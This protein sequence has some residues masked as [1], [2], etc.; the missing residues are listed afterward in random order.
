MGQVPPQVGHAR[1]GHEGSH[2]LQLLQALQTMQVSQPCVGDA[3]FVQP[4]RFQL[5]E[6]FETGEAGIGNLRGVQR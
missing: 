2:E 1:I 4:E 6:M 3:R 5:L